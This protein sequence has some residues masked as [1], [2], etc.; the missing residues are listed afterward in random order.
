MKTKFYIFALALFIMHSAALAQFVREYNAGPTANLKFSCIAKA[1]SGNYFIAGIQDTSVYVSE[2][3]SSGNVVRE[4]LVGI[5]NNAYTLT[6]MIVDADGNIAIVGNKTLAP[7]PTMAFLMKLSPALSI[8]LHVTYSN[9]NTTEPMGFTDVKDYKTTGANSINNAYYVSGYNIGTATGPDAVLMRLDRNTGAS[10]T[11]YDGQPTANST[12]DIYDALWLDSTGNPLFG[13]SVFVTGRLSSGNVSTFRPWV[14]KHNISTLA[15]TKGERYLEDIQPTKIERLYNA[16][17]IK[18]GTGILYC[19]YGNLNGT[20]YPKAMGLSK[21]DATTLLP[22]WQKQYT[23]TPNFQNFVILTK[24]A[25][26]PQGYVSHGQWWDSVSAQGEIFLI[27]SDKNGLPQWS[28]QY[29]NVLNDVSTHNSA[30]LIDGATIYA[31][32]YKTVSGFNRG[33]LIKTPLATGSMDTTCA[34]VLTVQTAD[35]TFRKADSLSKL[36]LAVTAKTDY[37][38]INCIA[39]GGTKPCDTCLSKTVTLNTDFTLSG[40]LVGTSPTFTLTASAYSILNNSQFVVSQVS[41]TFPYP[42]ITTPNTVLSIPAWGTTTPT[43]S[44]INYQGSDIPATTGNAGVFNSG[45]LYRVRHIMSTV[46]NCGVIFKDTTSK[47]ILLVPGLMAPKTRQLLVID[48]GK[49]YVNLNSYLP[50]KNESLITVSKNTGSATIFPNPANAFVIF[51][52]ADLKEENTILKI[53]NGNGQTV[54]TTRFA[55]V[56]QSAVDIHTWANGLYLYNITSNGKV[57]A[58]GKF[59]VQH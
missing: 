48:E 45:S 58:Q 35:S 21:V 23:V 49:G 26:D 32:G 22:A 25:A 36:P 5:G 11:I 1:Q 59:L 56:K 20:G 40:V 46:N 57:V 53:V 16:N 52:V 44:F 51:N 10:L 12:N 54:G 2:V 43:T 38:P 28:R 55:N 8:L 18:D 19:W 7:K 3:N 29:K 14:T 37:Y 31:I 13:P 50:A 34:L 39:T 42:D 15:F 17:I 47:I 24:V 27:R 30:F 33:V 41:P 4:K 9:S 6:A